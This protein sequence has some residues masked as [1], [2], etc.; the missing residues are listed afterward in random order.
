MTVFETMQK[1]EYKMLPS[2]FFI[3][4]PWLWAFLLVK[5]IDSPWKWG[6]VLVAWVYSVLPL[7][8]LRIKASSLFS[9]NSVSV[10]FYLASVD[11]E[12]QDFGHNIS[13]TYN[14]YHVL[15]HIRLLYIVVIQSPSHVLLFETPWTAACQASLSLTITW[16]SPKFMSIASVMPFSYL[17]LCHTLLLLPS[18]FPS[19]RVLSNES[20]VRL[21][22]QSI[23]ASA[24]ASVFPM[25]IQCWFLLRL[26]GLISLLFKRL[27]RVFSSTTVWKHRFFSALPSLW[28]S[29]HNCT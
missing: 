10:L 28:S 14:I 26:T 27:S 22:D 3:I 24:S 25:S 21:R 4:C 11:R 29:S 8:Q 12:S 5:H 18:I 23:G 1:E 2:S 13:S 17:I 20:V 15:Y 7:H 6:T 9:P 16:S 19:I